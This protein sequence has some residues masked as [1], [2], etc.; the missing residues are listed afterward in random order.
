MTLSLQL[1]V[2]PVRIRSLIART[3]EE[4][5]TFE[6]EIRRDPETSKAV[7][8]RCTIRSL[9]GLQA[10]TVAELVELISEFLKAGGL[11]QIE[12]QIIKSDS[13]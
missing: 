6:L 1:T 11:A 12:Q 7:L 2:D 3:I 10:E 4:R 8:A 13:N 9:E 5:G